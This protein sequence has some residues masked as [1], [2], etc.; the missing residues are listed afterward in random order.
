MGASD[1]MVGSAPQGASYAAPLVG[2]Q[3]GEALSKLPERNYSPLCGSMTR[4]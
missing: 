1:Y 4:V 3:F 2:F